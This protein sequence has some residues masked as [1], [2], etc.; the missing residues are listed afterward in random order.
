MDGKSF[1][2]KLGA[3][4]ASGGVVKKAIV[5][6]LKEK[7]G[8]R[9]LDEKGER[10]IVGVSVYNDVAS[11]TLDTSGEGLHKR[12]Y[13]TLTLEAPLK[14]T[15]AAAMVESSVYHA[16]K[17]FADLFCGS[18]TLPIEAALYA[19]NIAPNARRP[20][21]FTSWK[22]VPDVLPRVREEA[23]DLRDRVTKLELFASDIS[24]HAVS[25]A[26]YHAGR[27]GVEKHIRFVCADMREFSSAERYG[28]LLSN[29]PYGERLKE[30]DLFALYR[31][32]GKVYRALPD[33]SCYFLSGFEGAERAFGGRAEKRRK[34]YNANIPC[35]LYG[36]LGAKPPKNK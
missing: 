36:Y 11:F 26:R 14:E 30:D 28:V 23:E 27:A 15:V 33:W 7:L 12:G 22:C 32:F 3:V 25:V 6:C 20:F 29:P 1:K 34:L 17:P 8:V 4:K 18:G 19:L 13:R 9:S 24:E 35:G 5:E 21:D 31:D 2:S 16:G 10:A